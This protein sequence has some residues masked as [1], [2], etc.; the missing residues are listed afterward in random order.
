MNDTSSF[1]ALSDSN[2]S[3]CLC[4]YG[5]LDFLKSGA[6]NQ[7]VGYNG[8]YLNRMFKIHRLMVERYRSGGGNAAHLNVEMSSKDS[9]RLAPFLLESVV[10]RHDAFQKEYNESLEC[11][12]GLLYELVKDWKLLCEPSDHQGTLSP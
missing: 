2:Q 6:I 10:R 12:L 1:N 5:V 11:S 7:K 9:V 4:L 8:R 3:C